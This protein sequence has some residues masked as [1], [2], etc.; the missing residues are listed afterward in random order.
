MSVLLVFVFRLLGQSS[1]FLGIFS[2]QQSLVPASQ[3]SLPM[4]TLVHP[5][6]QLSLTMHAL[7]ANR[8]FIRT[9]A[10]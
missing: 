2:G 3:S 6:H 1:V 5:S 10:T 9:E 8:L 7:F 4:S